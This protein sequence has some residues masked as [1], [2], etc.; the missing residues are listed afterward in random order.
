M[1]K[2]S[3]PGGSV[4]V[5]DLARVL[6]DASLFASRSGDIPILNAVHLESTAERLITVATDRFTLGSATTNYLKDTP[7]AEFSAVLKLGQAQILSRIAK[8]CKAAFSNVRISAD[9][10]S[11][12]FE[13]T[14]GE[15]L[16]LPTGVDG[17]GKLPDWR[18]VI[19]ALSDNDD[20]VSVIGFS[21]AYLAKFSKV[22]NANRMAIKFAGPRRGALVSISDEFLGVIMPIRLTDSDCWKAPTWIERPKP[23]PTKTTRSRRTLAKKAS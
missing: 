10:A 17:A 5:A 9:D 12:T 18:K 16:T 2:D 4:P 8:S 15:R 3:I 23:K 11:A 7:G 14:S 21:P 20:A 22:T 6:D 13:F 19:G 1:N